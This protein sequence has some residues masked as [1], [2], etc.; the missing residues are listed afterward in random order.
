MSAPA[1]RSIQK[2]KRLARY[3]L[4]HPRAVWKYGPE[5][6][7]GVVAVYSDSDWGGC[8]RTR[9]ST[10]G[11][12]IALDGGLL[13]TWSTTQA[14]VALSSAEAEYYALVKAASEGLGIIALGRDLGW[15]Y[16]MKLWV[17]ASSAKALAQRQGF[18]R[19]KHIDARLLWVQEA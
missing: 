7:D 18:G 13:R 12:M 6:E 4:Q 15:Q 10:S 2:L 17:D 19:T 9:R 5:S 8:V 16:S 3:V 11:G 14:S 1:E